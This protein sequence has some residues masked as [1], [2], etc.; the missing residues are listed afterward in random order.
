MVINANLAGKL[1]VIPVFVTRASLVGTYTLGGQGAFDL[2]SRASQWNILSHRSLN[3]FRYDADI[4]L[5]LQVP[6]NFVVG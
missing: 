2:G 1:R 5:N 6:A 4:T 3:V